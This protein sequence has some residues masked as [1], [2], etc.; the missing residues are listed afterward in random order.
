METK[1]L[2]FK[3]DGPN[4]NMQAFGKDLISLLSNVYQLVEAC[5]NEPPSI[6][7]VENN[8]I[9]IRL[10]CS[11]VV[12]L[13]LCSNEIGTIKSPAKYNAAIRAINSCLHTHSAT[14]EFQ[15]V[16]NSSICRFGDG[17]ELPSV[18]ETHREVQTTM[19]IYGELVDVGGANPNAHIR[20]DAFDEDVKIDVDRDVAKR[21]ATRLYDQ[22]GVT[23]NIVIR[24]GRV[25]GGRALSVIDYD[26]QPI[27]VWLKANEDILGA[28]AFKGMDIDA[29]IAEQRK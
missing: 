23:A 26:P 29:F 15:D 18:P 4:V 28:D 8:C 19:T 2:V 7:A 3:F 1:T 6:M 14:L 10:L 22:I 21:L 25:V 5:S 12:G 17:E 20:S 27:D 16:A 11:A 24:D 13:S 9:T